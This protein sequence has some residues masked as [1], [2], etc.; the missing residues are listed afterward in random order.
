MTGGLISVLAHDWTCIVAKCRYRPR[1]VS[2]LS[3]QG[4]C[5]SEKSLGEVR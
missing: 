1:L 3:W 5:E 4:V 2:A